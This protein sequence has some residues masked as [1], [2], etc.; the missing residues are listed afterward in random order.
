MTPREELGRRL[1]R[2]LADNRR[3][4]PLQAERSQAVLDGYAIGKWVPVSERLPECGDY[5]VRN[6]DGD[7][8]HCIYRPHYP[9]SE[10]WM[11]YSNG[12]ETYRNVVS[13]LDL[14]LPEV[15]S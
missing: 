4:L 13:W 10:R 12:D 8:F 2:E 7:E 11:C 14:Q 1:G 6:E 3:N 5:I 15:A 9:K